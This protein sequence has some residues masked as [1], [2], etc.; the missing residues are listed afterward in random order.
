[1]DVDES[2][3]TVKVHSTGSLITLMRVNRLY[4]KIKP[5]ETIWFEGLLLHEFP[6]ALL[7]RNIKHSP[8]AILTYIQSS[9]GRPDIVF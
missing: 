9:H 8:D 1:M 7:D 6:Y 5:A 3:L 2:S 4:E